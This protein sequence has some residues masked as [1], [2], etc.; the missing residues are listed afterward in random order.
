MARILESRGLQALVLQVLVPS[1]VHQFSR[2]DSRDSLGKL[3]RSANQC[4]PLA[5][6][7]VPHRDAVANGLPYELLTV[8]LQFILAVQCE[9][10]ISFACTLILYN[11]ASTAG[12]TY[13]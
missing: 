7:A 10:S 5:K 8:E 9:A 11:G 3:P 1:V 4:G 13:G 12:L 2:Q 6:D